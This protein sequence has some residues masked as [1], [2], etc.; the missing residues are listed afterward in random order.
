MDKLQVQKELMRSK[1]MA[2]FDRYE[3]GDLFYN[4]DFEGATYQFPIPTIDEVHINQTIVDESGVSADIII[5][6]K[7]HRPT[8]DVKGAAF[9]T[10][11][12]ASELFRWIKKAID[13]D[14]VILVKKA[15]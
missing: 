2:T 4:F 15:I 6:A 3:N 5:T 13:K 14:K 11:M 9:C 12:R 7:V 8:P 10:E 1:S